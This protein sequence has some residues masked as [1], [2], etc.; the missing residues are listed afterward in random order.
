MRNGPREV[1]HDFDP[2]L[3]D[4]LQAFHLNLPNEGDFLLISQFQDMSPDEANPLKQKFGM[5][6]V[7]C[8]VMFEMLSRWHISSEFAMNSVGLL[9]SG[10]L[11]RTLVTLGVPLSQ[12]RRSV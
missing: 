12:P 7:A 2:R 5:S 9:A 8:D 6:L 4:T 1:H 10:E 11:A 3:S